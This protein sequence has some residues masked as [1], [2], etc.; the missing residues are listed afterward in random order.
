MAIVP[1]SRMV[2]CAYPPK[3]LG[4]AGDTDTA[5]GTATRTSIARQN[6]GSQAYLITEM[7]M[8]SEASARWRWP[9]R[10]DATLKESGLPKTPVRGPYLLGCPSRKLRASRQISARAS[11]S[12]TARH[13]LRELLASSPT[14][15]GLRRF[16]H[17]AGS[18]LQ[19]WI[20]IADGSS[21]VRSSRTS[22]PLPVL[23]RRV[24]SCGAFDLWERAKTGWTSKIEVRGLD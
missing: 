5:F 18:L 19:L 24:I 13:L 7:N 17:Q 12:S 10:A 6:F 4:L 1:R 20:S 9:L 11:C 8:K 3:P 21:P 16:P 14:T 15:V 23:R 22:P 2:V